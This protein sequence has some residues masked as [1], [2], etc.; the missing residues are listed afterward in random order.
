MQGS[1]SVPRSSALDPTPT[2]PLEPTASDAACARAARAS[3]DA[4]FASVAQLGRAA[5]TPQVVEMFLAAGSGSTA[6]AV[7]LIAVALL[8]PALVAFV[9]VADESHSGKQLASSQRRCGQHAALWRF[10]GAARS[11]QLG[12]PAASARPRLLGV[13]VVAAAASRAGAGGGSALR[14]LKGR[15]AAWVR[16]T[17]RRDRM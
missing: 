2:S 13:P 8:A 1:H 5:C 7:L 10:A 15:G 16:W 4:E 3:A 12:V 17:R 14:R 11:W 9:L 6:G